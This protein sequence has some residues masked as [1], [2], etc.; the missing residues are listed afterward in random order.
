MKFF[1]INLTLL[2]LFLVHWE[3]LH[4]KAKDIS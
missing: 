1:T 2:L 4:K 3:H